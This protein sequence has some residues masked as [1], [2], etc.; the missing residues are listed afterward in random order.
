MNFKKYIF[1]SVVCIL[2]L[3]T[4]CEDYLDI[5]DNPNAATTAPIN[6]LL[7]RTTTQ[8]ASNVTRMAG[9]TNFFVQY[10]ASPNQAS[11]SD[12]YDQVD[13]SGTWNSLY[14]NMTDIYDLITLGEELGSD[15][16]TG[17][18]KTLMA[19]NL[20]M[21]ID[22]WGD[23][24][25]SEA[26]L[27][28]ITDPKYDDAAGLYNTILTLLNEANTLLAPLEEGSDDDEIY[29]GDVSKW[30]KT[31]SGLRARYMNHLSGT[32]DYDPS[33]V[34]S[35][36][37]SAYDS[38]DDNA[39]MSTFDVR[40]P[41]NQVAVDN[42]GLNLGGW[43]SEQ[44]MD[45]MNGTSKGYVDPRISFY[46]DPFLD[47]NGVSTFGG[48]VNGAGR[49]GDGTIPEE[50]YINLT[51]TYSSEDA[52]IV[53]LSHY[54]LKFIEAEAY[55]RQSNNGDAGT[56]LRAAIESHMTYVGVDPASA[57]QYILDAGVDGA[58]TLDQV[59]EEKYIAMFL[60]PEAWVDA[61]RFNYNYA[62][63]SLPENAALSEYVR[64]LQ[65]PDVEVTRN[66]N[67]PT[68]ADQTERI[69]WN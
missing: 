45:A 13:Y 5:N 10:Q 47:M 65:Y 2:L 37:A 53:I 33:A 30:V 29:Q 44:L 27:G 6:G 32:S 69:F 35:A 66:K 1:G 68:R 49:K 12:I 52:P 55:A 16:H 62:D 64:S 17:V 34:L 7:I 28:E 21:A 8:T 48:T 36:V 50:C 57:A 31:I 25:Y 3:A 23:V 60:H 20:A 22:A 54:E 4:G 46:T 42:I 43:L 61:R 56:A 40:N 39:L 41:W 24:P 14:G 58:V 9:T 26:F 19:V 63:F 67:T 11:G 51:G 59:M 18:G 38:N 15:F